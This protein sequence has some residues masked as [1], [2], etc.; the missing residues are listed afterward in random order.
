MGRPYFPTRQVLTFAAT[1]DDGS[2]ETRY[3]VHAV[4]ADGDLVAGES[5]AK[6]SPTGPPD[7]CAWRC[8]WRRGHPQ[9]KRSPVGRAA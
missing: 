4:T 9:D 1:L 7:A 3:L 5:T 2:T 8:R 6:L